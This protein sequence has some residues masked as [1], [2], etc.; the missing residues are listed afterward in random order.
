MDPGQVLDTLGEL[1]AYLGAFAAKVPAKSVM[2]LPGGF[3]PTEEAIEKYEE[4]VYKFRDRAGLTY[5]VL[6]PVFV[7]SLEAFEA[8]KV[9]DAVPPLMQSV[10]H[11]VELHHQQTVTFTSPQQQRLREYHRRLEKIVP[12]ATQPE[13]DLPT[14]ESY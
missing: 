10:E 14:P 6:I 2:A 1:I 5:K 3:R 8:G 9:F 7:N 4:T 11:L 12:E 13:V